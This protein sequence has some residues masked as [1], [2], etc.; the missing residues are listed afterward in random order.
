MTAIFQFVLWN[1]KDM[2]RI[3]A[4]DL[5]WNFAYAK[6]P[7]VA[8]IWA[9]I[10]KEYLAVK[11]DLRDARIQY[12]IQH[13]KDHFLCSIIEKE[14]GIQG[15]FCKGNSFANTVVCERNFFNLKV[16]HLRWFINVSKGPLVP[17][18]S[19]EACR[20]TTKWSLRRE[21]TS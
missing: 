21:F 5:M 20:T 1:N 16:H 7:D 14:S 10:L 17:Q 8:Q 15:N 9:P 3:L 2:S 11:D 13:N 12:V 6:I 19:I 4:D 18:S